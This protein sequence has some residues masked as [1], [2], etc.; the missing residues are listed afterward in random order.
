MMSLCVAD[1][2]W[3]HA[4]AVQQNTRLFK[5]HKLACCMMPRAEASEVSLDVG[6]AVPVSVCSIV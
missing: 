5:L 4:D 2:F 6:L 1:R 3:S